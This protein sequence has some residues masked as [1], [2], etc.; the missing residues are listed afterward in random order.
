LD[1]KLNPKQTIIT[2]INTRMDVLFFTCRKCKFIVTDP[3]ECSKC[4]TLI[5]KECQKLNCI[6]ECASTFKRPNKF[7][8]KHLNGL[9]FNCKAKDCNKFPQGAPYK[10]ILQHQQ[11][12]IH[13]S[14]N[15][16]NCE[17]GK[18]FIG[19][20]IDEHLKSC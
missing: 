16:P 20:Q 2:D 1:C 8:T 3:L 6:N 12:C 14:Y 18:I 17:D 13:M 9:T 10:K 15:C 19:N 11:S 4:E 7:V 5:C